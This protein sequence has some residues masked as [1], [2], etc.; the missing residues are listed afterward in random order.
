MSKIARST[1]AAAFMLSACTVGPNYQAPNDP[2]PAQFTKGGVSAGAAADDE[3]LEVWWAGFRDPVLSGLIQ[4]AIEGNY[5]LQ[6]AGQRIREADDIVRV[7]GSADLPQIGFGVDTAAHRQSQTLD[8]PP[9]DAQ[10][11]EYPYYQLGF[12]ASWEIDVFGETRRRK[13]SA[14][15]AA[16]AAVEY[17]HGV[18][19]SLT[20]AVATTYVSYR[21]AEARLQIANDD[22]DTAQKIQTL[23][24]R[25]FT[26]GQTSHL[27]VSEADAEVDAVEAAIPPLQA[28]ADMLVHA[29]A[30]LLG[31]TP[32]AFTASNMP[33]D[34]NIPVAP[35]LPASMPSEVIAR[36]PDIRQA[37]RDYAEAN[38]NVGVAIAAEYPHFSIPLMIGPST[39]AWGAAFELASES[40]QFGLLATQSLYTGGALG[41]KV[42]AAEANKQATLLTYRE[43]VLKAFAEV[44]DSLSNQAAEEEQF[45]A[46]TAQ[47]SSS[48]QALDEATEQY[49]N[50]QV[51]FLPVLDSQ[52]ELYA[53]QD[54]LV[55][56]SLGRTLANI[57]L[58]KAIGGGW[59]GV[60]LPDTMIGA[61]WTN[62]EHG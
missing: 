36:R 49:R 3:T 61:T 34:T 25:S 50:G 8:W 45:V 1:L 22:L 13:E 23:T 54:A 15:D 27:D 14:R 2:E 17:R 16:E 46:V 19:V 6:I 52:R 41:A 30:V 21:A 24:D 32:E 55:A 35:P 33:E 18:M 60:A 53:A 26:A 38:A 40:W 42:D 44:E 7:A 56:A 4:Q 59:Q 51:G 57:N 28:Q 43:T 12:D 10:Y 29:M 37:E 31:K 47:V 58:Y 62:D 11:G 20:A 9:P 48:Q 5:N 39:S